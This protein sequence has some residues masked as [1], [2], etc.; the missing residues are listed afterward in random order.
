M[1]K[2]D[3][4]KKSGQRLSLAYVRLVI[5]HLMMKSNSE[6]ASMS[7]PS[8]VEMAPSITGA[9]MCS[10]ATLERVFLF[11]IAVRKPCKDT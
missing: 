1:T 6:P 11:P 10:R 8:R 4:A 3:K 2:S 5:T 7:T 9:N